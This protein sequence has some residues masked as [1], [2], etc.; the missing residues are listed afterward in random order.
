[1]RL[2]CREVV[3]QARDRVSKVRLLACVHTIC[4][5]SRRP[6]PCAP[7]PPA[8]AL[9]A[10]NLAWLGSWRNA[11]VRLAT[12]AIPLPCHTAFEVQE[13]SDRMRD[14]ERRAELLLLPLQAQTALRRQERRS[15]HPYQN[16]PSSLP[17]M[18]KRRVTP[19]PLPSALPSPSPKRSGR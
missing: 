10:L 5:N 12:R 6:S 9:A 17:V 8:L 15:M 19:E 14:R 11:R 7:W 1:M 13:G 16:R 2:D 18:A 4:R 3:R